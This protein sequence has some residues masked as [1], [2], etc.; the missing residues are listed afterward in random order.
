MQLNLHTQ[1]RLISVKTYEFS[2]RGRCRTSNKISVQPN[3]R[4]FIANCKSYRR[5]SDNAAYNKK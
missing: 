3:S 5:Q 2:K 1:N 4:F